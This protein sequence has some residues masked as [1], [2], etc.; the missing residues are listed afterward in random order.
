M[1]KLFISY[2]R[3]DSIGLAGRI[4][5]RLS[6]HFGQQSVFIDVD[7]IPIG[8]DFRVHLSDAVSQCDVLVAI[9]GEKWLTVSQ[10]GHRRLDDPRDLVRIEIETA[11][12][13]GIPVIPVLLGRASMPR[14]E[15]LP[16]T[17]AALAFRNATSVDPGR[18]FHK[19]V[20]RLIRALLLLAAK[21]AGLAE[22]QAPPQDVAA[23]PQ[24]Q[25]PTMTN[26]LGMRFAW[27]PP[28][29]GFLGGGGG[30]PGVTRFAL[31]QGLWCGIYLVTQAE[32]Q[33]VMGNNPSEF[34]GHLRFPVER[35]T[36]YDVE[37]FLYQ[38]NNV[39]G[40]EGYSYRLPTAN[41]WEYICRGGPVSQELSK[42][43]FYFAKSKTDLTP[44]PIDQLS[45]TEAN[46]GELM[47]PSEVGSYLPNSLGIY[48]LHGNVWEWTS[49]SKGGVQVLRGGGWFS[50]SGDCAAA[51]EYPGGYAPELSYKD[52]GLR[53]LAVPTQ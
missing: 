51:A 9:I 10:N 19:N 23:E 24:G 20:D 22:V 32:W 53:L 40:G 18:D 45:D 47:R 8:V 12:Q 44:N 48:D 52:L 34:A 14:E 26:A 27:V 49:T 11:L 50:P 30:H 7:T 35:V 39:H 46:I 33:R 15:E 21:P 13:R 31:S 4:Y 25:G 17:L 43:H 42:F 29:V 1:P 37:L 36:Y 16:T 38:L 41:Q 3:E 2:R 28:G 5:D 6:T